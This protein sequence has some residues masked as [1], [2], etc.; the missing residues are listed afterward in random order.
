MKTSKTTQPRASDAL[1]KAETVALWHAVSNYEL[2]IKQLPG[3]EN[4]SPEVIA[5]ERARLALAKTALRKVNRLR[6]HQKPRK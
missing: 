4:L 2:M 6:E 5:E 1:T 3:I